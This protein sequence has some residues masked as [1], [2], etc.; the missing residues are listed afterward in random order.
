M[1]AGSWWNDPTIQHTV[2]GVHVKNYAYT[3]KGIELAPTDIRL[4]VH[5]TRANDSELNLKRILTKHPL[6]FLDALRN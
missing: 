5:Q 3:T 6:S 1:D 2:V 4:L